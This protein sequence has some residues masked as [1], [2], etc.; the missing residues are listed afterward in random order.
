M[1][2][3]AII[4]PKGS[5]ALEQAIK[6]AF[7]ENFFRITAGQYLVAVAGLT[8]Q[9]VGAKVGDKGEVGQILVLPFDK[10]W[11]WHRMDMWEWADA[12]AQA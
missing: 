4:A 12:R 8:G 9:E 10:R 5:E 3:F 2:V 7:P 6:T 1:Q 11:G